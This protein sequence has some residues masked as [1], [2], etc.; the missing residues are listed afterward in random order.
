MFSKEVC[1]IVSKNFYV[2]DCLFSVPTTEQAIKTS[3][4]LILLL[5]EGNYLFPTAKRYWL[6]FLRRKELSRILILIS[7]PLKEHLG[8]NGTLKLIYLA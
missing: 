6:P 3:L 5:K 2:D 7:F 8:Y 1:D 4:Q